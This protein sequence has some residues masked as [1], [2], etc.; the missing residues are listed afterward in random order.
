MNN[1]FS[2]YGLRALALMTVL[3]MA[4]QARAG[5]F[6]SDYGALEEGDETIEEKGNY[7]DSYF[8]DIEEGHRLNVFVHADFDAYLIVIDPNGEQYEN[9]DCEMYEGFGLNPY[10]FPEPCAGRWEVMVTSYD[11][12]ITGNYAVMYQTDE[13]NETWGF[14]FGAATGN[15]WVEVATAV[16][17]EKDILSIDCISAHFD[18]VLKVVT[19]SGEEIENDDA[20]AQDSETGAPGTNSAIITE[21]SEDGNYTIFVKSF[22]EELESGE[23]IV[24]YA[25]TSMSGEEEGAWMP[26]EDRRLAF[27]NP[28]D[29]E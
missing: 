3:A 2:G 10:V 24:G 14:E 8:L 6:D 27:I 20:E 28:F 11:P 17:S 19:P 21:C 18:T 16:A 7:F 29:R 23:F 1:I 26:L 25:V 22:D 4:S 13:E 15:E 5:H 9:D 12:A